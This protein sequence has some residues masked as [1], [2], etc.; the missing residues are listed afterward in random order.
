MQIGQ[1][2]QLGWDAAGQL[3][4]PEVKGLQIGQVAQLGWDAA[5]ELVAG[6][7]KGGDT[8]SNAEH[9]IPAAFCP[10]C[11]IPTAIIAPV[12]TIGAIVKSN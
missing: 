11:T 9:P 2:A 5:G 7:A 12:V 8:I 3:V 1:V 10:R 6:K 4:V